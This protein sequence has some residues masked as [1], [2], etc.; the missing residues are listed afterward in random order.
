MVALIEASSVDADLYAGAD[1]NVQAYISI[2]LDCTGVLQYLA[3]LVGT[4]SGSSGSFL[5]FAFCCF[6]S[7]T[8][9]IIGNDPLILSG[10]PFLVYFTRHA[11]ITPH[12]QTSF[13]F[14]HFQASNLVSALLVSSNPTNLVLTSAFGISFLQYS[15]WLALPT[16]AGM[17]VLY[18]ILRYGVFRNRIPRTLNPPK[19]NPKDSLIDPWGG[20]FGTVLFVVV[21]ILLVSLSAVGL[22]EGVQGVWSITAPAGIIMFVRDCWHDLVVRRRKQEEI[23]GEGK[24]KQGM[25]GVEKDREMTEVGKRSNEGG[26][27][28]GSGGKGATSPVPELE[29]ERSVDVP[30]GQEKLPS[31][32]S[33]R[34][35]SPQSDTP[36]PTPTPEPELA[37]TNIIPANSTAQPTPNPGGGPLL[38]PVRLFIHLF[39]TA[40]LII[41][42]LPLQLIPFAFSMFILVEALSY[43]GWIRVFAGWWAAWVDVGGVGGAIW[44]MGMIS[45][46]GC[47]AFGT[48]IGATVLLS[49]ESIFSNHHLVLY[50]LHLLGPSDLLGCSG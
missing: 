37:N 13:L 8:G 40:S 16:I 31:G 34:A 14:T 41:T 1:T 30:H 17:I 4:K 35:V 22:L 32:S 20:V 48:N 43:T 5:Y 49:R 33:S 39:P 3:H 29:Q 27:E 21:I 46:L 10:T 24:R 38:A 26:G 7:L 19:V 36:T 2:S 18:P 47:N 45:V 44:L 9:L 50:S 6:F 12:D 28:G 42:R 11:A 15:A 25:V 23:S